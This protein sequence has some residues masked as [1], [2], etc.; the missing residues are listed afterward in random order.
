MSQWGPS[1]TIA[2][3]LALSSVAPGGLS[4]ASV[5]C[6]LLTA[7]VKIIRRTFATID[8]QAAVLDVRGALKIQ[9]EQETHGAG[10]HEQNSGPRFEFLA[11]GTTHDRRT[12]RGDVPDDHVV[13]AGI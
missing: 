3:P 13:V 10:R 9:V 6:T 7:N 5:V 1:S 2:L 12:A 4:C 8:A 11:S